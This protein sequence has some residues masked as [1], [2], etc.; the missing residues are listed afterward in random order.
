MS[1]LAIIPA[2]GGSKGVPG[3]NLKE[4]GGRSLI[5]RAVDAAR[6]SGVCDHVLVSTE[7][8]AIA[9][10]ARRAGAEVPFPRP[11]ALAKDETA[12][13]PVIA[14]AIETYEELIGRQVETLVFLEATVPFRRPEHISAAV[15]RYREGD[16]NSVV[17]V[18]PLERKPENILEKLADRTVE[19]YI[20]DPQN[21]F[22]RRQ[23]MEHI[24]RI[25]SGA[26]VVGRNTWF[27]DQ[28]LV[29]APVGFVEMDAHESVN[30][31]SEIDLMLAELIAARYGI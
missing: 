19:R 7:D 20:R 28:Q 6:Q 29:V 15:T 12:M 8:A 3:K 21:V 2:R 27:V 30:I 18:C 4:I 22:A 17:T 16:V 11:A 9:E 14:H 10:E 26:Y 23:D 1:V 5:A 25:S 31:D 24:C 13:P